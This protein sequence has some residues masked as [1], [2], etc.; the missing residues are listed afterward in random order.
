MFQGFAHSMWRGLM[1]FIA[2]FI[3]VLLGMP[4]GGWQDFTLG[5][6]LMILAHYAEKQL[7]R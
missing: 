2:F 1:A 7:T 5:T 6:L 3:P 4:G